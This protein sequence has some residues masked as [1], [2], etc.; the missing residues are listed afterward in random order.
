MSIYPF[1][2]LD[3]LK[4]ASVNFNLRATQAVGAALWDFLKR[5]DNVVRM[6]TASD[7]ERAAVEP[8]ST[9]LV[10]EFGPEVAEDRTKQMIGRMVRQIME[11][12]GYELERHGLRIARNGLFTSGARYRRV[13]ESEGRRTMRITPEQRRAWAERTAKSPFT[14]WLD[15]QVRGEDGG[16]DLEKLYS[17]ARE[18]GIEDRY[19]RHDPSQQRM[20]IGVMLRE[21]VPPEVYEEI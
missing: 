6:H 11:A 8:L 1:K 20:Q 14:R 15:Q 7:L 21:V 10:A 4:Y 3:R 12:T 19:D 9:G 16:L 13:G 2:E 5:P 17:V 18:Y